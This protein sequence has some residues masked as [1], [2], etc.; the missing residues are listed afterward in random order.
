MIVPFPAGGRTDVIGRIVAQHLP[1]HLGKPV[2]VVNKPGA[3]S[4]LGSKEV[5]Q[6]RPDGYTVGFLFDLRGDRAVHRADAALDLKRFRAG[7]HRQH[8]SGRAGGA[9]IRRPG[10]RCE[11]LVEHARQNPDRLRIGMIPGASAQIFAAGFAKA[12][13]CEADR[14]AVQGRQRRRGRARRRTYRGP[15]R[16]AGLLQEPGRGQEGEDPG[17]GGRKPVAALRQ[18]ADV[19]RERRRPGDRRIPRRVRAEGNA[20][21]SGRQARRRAGEDHGRARSSSPT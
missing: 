5:A 20:A 17:G 11:D 15:C 10:R 7:R 16:G 18:P 1:K 2:A 4:V 6:A 8:R 9:G 21:G 3:S 14:C 13:G 12:A 19:P